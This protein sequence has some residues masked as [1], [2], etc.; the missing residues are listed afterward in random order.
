MQTT[1][2]K[3]AS[4]TNDGHGASFF[5]AREIALSG[6][7]H[8]MLSDQ[9]QALNFRLRFSENGY[10]S[11]WHVAGDPTLLL[12]LRG[13]IEIELR[14]GSSKVFSVGELFIAEDYL[15]DG[16]AFDVELAGHRA[17]VLGGD[18]LQA[19]HLKLSKR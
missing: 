17:R 3:I 4:V 16:V 18:E 12:I 11:D 15:D 19:L 10:E 8:W 7:S 2:K 1:T 9:Q 13:S 6:S 5:S 14:D